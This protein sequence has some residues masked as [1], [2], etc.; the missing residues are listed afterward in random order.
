M[1]FNAEGERDAGCRE[2]GNHD[3]EHENV[4]DQGM[5]DET[6]LVYPKRGRLGLPSRNNDEMRLGIRCR[7][8]RRLGKCEVSLDGI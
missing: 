3:V 1:K 6:A 8:N 7:L 5:L 4:P 2:N